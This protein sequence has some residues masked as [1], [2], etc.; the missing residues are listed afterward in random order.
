MI[1]KLSTTWQQKT[2]AGMTFLAPACWA[3]G[4]GIKGQYAGPA[5][6]GNPIEVIMEFD[7][8]RLA[9]IL[10]RGATVVNEVME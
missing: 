8:S 9:G 10:A 6:A 1:A 5:V 3:P 4:E 7:E 2:H